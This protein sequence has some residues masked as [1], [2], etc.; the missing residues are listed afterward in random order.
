MRNSGR[1][2]LVG[3]ELTFEKAYEIAT[4][5][6]I[7]PKNMA[8]LQESKES[9]A[10]NKVTLQEAETTDRTRRLDGQSTQCKSFFR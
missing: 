10:V 2:L 9:E 5:M 6:E 4:S 1:R 8:V 3:E 7:T